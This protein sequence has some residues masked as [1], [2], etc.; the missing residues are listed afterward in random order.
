M[1]KQN[2]SLAFSH[3]I[4]RSVLLQKESVL[5]DAGGMPGLGYRAA[6]V[7]ASTGEIL[8]CTRTS[9][10]WQ[11]AGR[12]LAARRRWTIV[13]RPFA[14]QLAITPEHVGQQH[15][16]RRAV[17]VLTLN[18]AGE[19]KQIASLPIAWHAQPMSC[20]HKDPIFVNATLQRCALCG[21]ERS[22]EHGEHSTKA[23][24]LAATVASFPGS[25]GLRAF[26]GKTFR[27]SL[28]SS[29]FND[30]GEAMI[31]TQVRNAD[32]TWSDFAKSTDRELRSEIASAP[33][34]RPAAALADLAMRIAANGGDLTAAVATSEVAT[35]SAD[36]LRDER[37]KLTEQTE[38]L[39]LDRAMASAVTALNAELAKLPTEADRERLIVALGRELARRIGGRS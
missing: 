5:S 13:R 15:P 14:E 30:F 26:P 34:L 6:L 25:F 39:V 31:Y 32:G 7:C 22:E 12:A 11:A 10:D 28:A 8:A 3:P 18:T 38:Q 27:A 24:A 9:D 20:G 35:W 2:E 17:E 19:V 36:K 23:E 33:V 4:R 29:Y 21:I 16:S 1:T 37:V